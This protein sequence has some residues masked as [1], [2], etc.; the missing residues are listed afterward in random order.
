M[1]NSQKTRI[2]RRVAFWTMVAGMCLMVHA[3]AGVDWRLG[4]FAGGGLL[5]SFGF[6]TFPRRGE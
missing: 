4:C 6:L 2:E 3:L 5:T 1:S